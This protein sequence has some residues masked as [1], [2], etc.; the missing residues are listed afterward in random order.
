MQPDALFDRLRAC[1]EHRRFTELAELY[2]ADATF[3]LHIGQYHDQRK[4]RD[5]IV[6]RYAHDFA[7][8]ATFLRWDV[9]QAPWGAV[10]E[11][12]ALQGEENARAR[13]RW[14]HLLTIEGGRI[15]DDTLYCTGAVFEA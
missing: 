13:Y 11:A 1:F 6:E 14:V 7:A 4:G 15:T 3:E 12:D 5:S 9:R 10:V 8:P 2:A